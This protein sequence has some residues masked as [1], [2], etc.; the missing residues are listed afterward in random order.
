MRSYRT[1]PS[2]E[3]LILHDSHTVPAPNGEAF[4]RWRGRQNGLLDVGYHFVIERDGATI[5]TRPE[6]AIG[7]HCAGY[8]HNSIGVCLIGG[9]DAE[10]PT[11]NF[12]ADQRA[13]L[14]TLYAR[15]RGTYGPHL[16]VL[17]H[18]E[19]ARFVGRRRHQPCPCLDMGVLRDQLARFQATGEFPA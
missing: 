2:T 3:F 10:A 17:G 16:R 12:T 6:D 19:L 15:L 9:L 13:A 14:C 8:N 5:V 11:D 4:L 1:R 7:S 18:T